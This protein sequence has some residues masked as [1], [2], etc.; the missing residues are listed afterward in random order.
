[1]NKALLLTVFCTFFALT[2]FSQPHLRPLEK[3][4]S[5]AKAQM[6]FQEVVPFILSGDL[7]QWP[8]AKA[9]LIDG[10][11]L[12]PDLSACRQALRQKASNI[13]MAIPL[14]QGKTMWLDLVLESPLTESFTVTTSGS[15]GRPVPYSPGLHYRGVVRGEAHSLAAISIFENEIMG[16]VSTELDGPAVLG[17]LAN[18]RNRYIFYKE[19]DLKAFNEYECA[20]DLPAIRKVDLKKFKGMSAKDKSVNNCVNAYLECDYD[21]YLEQGSVA[22]TVD[23]I[24]GLFNVVSTL[25]AN[26]SIVLQAS[27]IFVWDTPDSYPTTTSFDALNAFRQARPTFNGHIAHLVSRGAPASGGVAWVDALCTPYAYGYSYIF[28]NYSQFPVYSWSVEVIAHE[29]GHNLGSPHTHACAWNGNNTAID[30]CGPAAGYSEGCNAP[31]PAKGTIMSYC[32]LV[33]GVG[34]DFNLGFGPQPGNLIRSRIANAPCLNNCTPGCTMTVDVTGTPADDGDNG[35]VT[36]TPVGGSA[37]YGYLWNNDATAASLSGLAPGTYTVTVTDA[38][39]CS[40]TGSYTVEDLNPC[41]QQALVLTIVLDNYPEETSWEI[42]D[43]SGVAVASS[44]GTYA[45]LAD[46]DTVTEYICLPAGCY[47]LIMYD[48]YGDGICCNYGNGSYSLL[49]VAT[50]QILA[51]G[52]AFGFSVS[53]NFCLLTSGG[54]GTGGCTWQ[55]IDSENF[56][57]GWGIWNDGG[58]DCSRVKSSTYAYSGRYS[59][60]LRDNDPNSSFMTTDPLD[61]SNAEELSVAFTYFPVSM[62][63]PAEDFWL[64]ISLDG[65]ATFTTVEEWNFGDE[66]V[67]LQR[68]FDTVSI[69]GPFSANTLLRF[70]CDASGNSDWVY[71]DDVTIS[72]CVNY[73]GNLDAPPSNDKAA[74]QPSTA[75]SSIPSLL[76]SQLP[77]EMVVFP[78][79]AKDVVN[80]RYE[81]G[82]SAPAN[83]RLRDWSGRIVKSVQLDAGVRELTLHLG[84]VGAGYYFLEIQSG[85]ERLSQKL[86]LMK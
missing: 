40:A 29:M 1:M 36:A 47:T 4:I 15:N 45:H 32:H 39:G 13:S 14:A 67:N 84:D 68:Y 9:D 31:L 70:T 30:G 57:S 51:A 64:Q 43:S 55:I 46:G 5:E 26:E 16:V 60:R 19:K 86:I 78:N 24:T 3:R 52:N 44:G 71:I 73:N 8:A 82:Q 20:S 61:L 41:T 53:H 22:A 17:P 11:I 50:G 58:A 74:S 35:T 79:P 76:N 62:D 12:K 10:I 25:Y 56:D 65:G 38:A 37:P 77:G 63:N 48:V 75:F 33:S 69:A 21:M 23:F 83:V 6:A 27:Q 49:E 18:D 54:G 2:L 85:Q 72:A 59:I 81:L 80:V 7:D 42:L 34:I 28:N 66:F